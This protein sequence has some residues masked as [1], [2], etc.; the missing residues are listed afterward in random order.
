MDSSTIPLNLV[1]SSIV[2]SLPIKFEAIIGSRTPDSVSAAL[3]LSLRRLFSRGLASSECCARTSH[4]G[5]ACEALKQRLRISSGKILAPKILAPLVS[6]IRQ[7]SYA[8][9]DGVTLFA[10]QIFEGPG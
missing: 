9:R 7:F 8:T 2:V 5:N 1:P 10:A 3:A 4:E 6:D